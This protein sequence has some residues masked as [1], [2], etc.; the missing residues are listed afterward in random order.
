MTTNHK[1]YKTTSTH[2]KQKNLYI[3]WLIA[4]LFYFY[5]Y[6][7]RV[8]PNIMAQELR[9]TF[10]VK[11]ETFSTLGSLYLLAY[12]LL[13]IPIGVMTDRVGVRKVIIASIIICICG[14]TI[15]ACTTNFT[16]LQLSRF[17]IGIGSA[18]AFMCSLKIIA[19]SFPAGKRGVLVGATLTFGTIGALVSG[20]I[21]ILLVR[22]CGWR[23]AAGISSIVGF[24]VLLLALFT[25]KNSAIRVNQMSHSILYNTT[26]AIKEGLSAVF[27]NRK[28]IIYSLLAIGLYTPLS[29]LAD[30]WGSSFLKMKFNLEYSQAADA[31]LMLYL[32]LGLGSM[33][34][35]WLSEKY[36][37][38]NEFIIVC[39]VIILAL[40]TL[41]IYGPTLQYSL[42]ITLMITIGFF[43]GSEMIC[44]TAALQ[45]SNK[46]SG[47][48]IGIVNTFNMLGN[49]I[50]QQIIGILLDSNW[51]GVLNT[52]GGRIYTL[53]TFII[54]MSSLVVIVLICCVMSVKLFPFKK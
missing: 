34:L 7:L 26:K 25:I 1:A 43:C 3:A 2:I 27:G 35:P 36:K 39:G 33:I 53:N 12:S 32:G 29:A 4:C 46:N 21:L 54:A 15:F 31:S 23:I 37:M 28:I 42:V 5:Q 17:M 24:T 8:A 51:D 16:L 20:H 41:M 50:L 18:P 44:F 10:L 48:I 30:L 9:D 13:Q 38:M 47:S 45:Y 49:A 40:T 11:A 52:N 19:D 14:S 22:Q 6:M